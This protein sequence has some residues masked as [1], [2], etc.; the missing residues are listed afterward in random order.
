MVR[1]RRLRVNEEMRSLVR[2]T[3]LQKSDLVLIAARPAMGKT[4]FVLNLI[5]HIA[6]H[7]SGTIAMFSLEMSK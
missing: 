3:S 7:G 1:M 4:S 5:E 6:L 2:E